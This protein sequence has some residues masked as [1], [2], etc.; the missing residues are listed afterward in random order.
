MALDKNI[1]PYYDDF[2]EFK[3]YHQLLFR[4][5]FS[6]QARELTQLQS[7][8]K[9]QIAK[10]GDHVFKHG[11]IVIPGN[12]RADLS[13][14]Y[15]KLETNYGS[16]PIVPS[17]WLDKVIV[18][19]TSGVRA[20]VKHVEPATATDPLTFYLAYTS[21][22]VVDDVANGKV[23]FDNGEDIYL[24]EDSGV[25]ATVKPTA[26]TGRG[27][28]AYVNRG[29]YYVNGTFV[30]VEK[31]AT[32]I[33]KYTTTPSCSV[34]LKITEEFVTFE[35]DQTL[36]DPAQGSYNFA[37][38]GADRLK[39]SLTLTSLPLTD[40]IG[41]DYIEIMRYRAGVLEE[42]ARN[43]KYN[44]LEKSLARRT[45]DE[46]GDYIVKGFETEIRE[47][48]REGNNGGVIKTGSRDNYAVTVSPGK[49][50][51]GGFEA[52]K[53][54]P[55]TLVAPKARTTSHIFT[56]TFNLR[57]TFG[58]FI[59][60]TNIVGGPSVLTR[61][62]IDIYND[63]DPL[64]G[65]ATKIGSARVIAID[66]HIGDPSSANAIY[67]LWL[68]D[69][70]YTS[71][72][73]TMDDAGGIRFTGGSAYVV[74][75]LNS[76]LSV[77]TH[78]IGNII[79]YSGTVRTATVRY[80]DS[81]SGN[82]Y[83]FKH[84]H[85]K[86]TP[87]AGDQIVNATTSATSVVQSK[88][89]YFGSGN[90]TAIFELPVE[91]VKSIR[92]TLNAYD[93]TYSV[94]KELLITTN[95]SGAGS[96][97]IASGTMQSPEVGTFVAF[98]D[99]G[100]VSPTLFSLNEAGNELSITG[101]PISKT[102][103]VYV[104]VD[105][106][107][108]IPRTKTL[109][110]G[111]NVKSMTSNQT[112]VTL[113]SPDAYSITSV[114]HSTL[115]D[116]TDR[117]YLDNGQSDYAYYLSS[118][119]LRPGE[120]APAGSLTITYQYFQHSEGD[121]F[122]YD[123][124]A[125]NANYTDYELFYTSQ[126]TGDVYDLKNCIDA[127]PSVNTSN[128]FGSGSVVGDMLVSGE[129]F[130]SSIQFYVP[131]I[132]ILL[133]S[134]NGRL[135]ILRG[136]PA[137]VPKAPKIPIDSIGVE[138]YYIPAYTNDI[139]NITTERLAVDRYTMK[140]I[141]MLSAR[142]DRLEEFSTLTASESGV[143]DYE[144]IDAET[145]LS[146]FK[147]GYLVETFTTPFTIADTTNSQFSATFDS[148]GMMPGVEFLD[149]PVTL[150][151]GLSSQY[152]ITN[153]MITVPYTEK[154]LAKQPMSSRVTNLNPFLVIKW[155]GVL[156]A[157]PNRDTWV[158]VVDNPE[159]LI[160]KTETT[161]IQ[162]WVYAPGAPA[163]SE[164]R[165]TSIAPARMTVANVPLIVTTA[166]VPSNPTPLPV[167]LPATVN[168]AALNA[169]FANTFKS[170]KIICT[171]LYELGIMPE[172]IYEA[173]QKFGAMIAETDP[174]LL[175][176]YQAWA[177]IVVD[178]MSGGGIHMGVSKMGMREW[179]INWAKDIAT[180]WSEEMAHQMGARSEGNK[181]GKRIMKIGG[182]LSRIVGKFGLCKKPNWFTGATL[183]AIFAVLK[184]IVKFSS[185]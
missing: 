138:S 100:T 20:I 156:F 21:G 73:V 97:S 177:S 147:T 167:A 155:D 45:Y 168:Q 139:A 88:Q 23:V 56:K 170:T 110:T 24:F 52:E 32:V 128:N 122:V 136:K 133:L 137:E 151:T 93:H 171:K 106:A 25:L 92:N 159:I 7:I 166:T 39:I 1:A 65:S 132:D 123:S 33:S 54:A 126:S 135:S 109:Q 185:K 149:C 153:G 75:V 175:A 80:W 30:S 150:M 130:T 152:Q 94:Q 181:A 107:A 162:R 38:P 115:G 55:T 64:N 62:A 71:V 102:I 95:G 16:V 13:V 89:S 148:G 44:E 96:V 37:A 50:Y 60:V 118:I 51:I 42:H 14:P 57:P 58:R 63:N 161:T 141:S 85:T 84:D 117:F 104:T 98:D 145:G 87:K 174:M 9:N 129:K 83:V 146:R 164:V 18:G 46:S 157:T 178:W 67:K 74:Q 99:T 31:Q 163:V 101:G 43:P 182:A 144:V 69:V 91:Y 11:S 40:P 120:I 41:D 27:S 82:L 26:A 184:L 66:Y 134:K 183:I 172:D 78:N 127:R 79:N 90:N 72:L 35:D 143:I 131:R 10:F 22:G 19:A 76:P 34:L 125:L 112:V 8:L 113:D 114:V 3:N 36:L 142:V 49:A 154:V 169:A 5:G 12:S 179:A 180:P 4:P 29:V 86:S 6:V 81:A 17:D 160:N 173:D 48:K 105:K 176:G 53:I 119:V 68:T 15:V 116:V 121:F 28:V 165:T 124:Y 77:G 158:E 47:H 140:D 70:V 108:V 2:D 111:I 103:R 61:Q 59:Y